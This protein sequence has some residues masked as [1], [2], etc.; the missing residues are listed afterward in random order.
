M[1]NQIYNVSVYS[2]F[3]GLIQALSFSLTN[4]LDENKQIDESKRETSLDE[5]DKTMQT[6]SA[7][8]TKIFEQGISKLGVVPDQNLVETKVLEAKDTEDIYL[9]KENTLLHYE[10]KGS[11]YK[12]VKNKKIRNATDCISK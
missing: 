11:S 4:Y 7:T 6:D 9:L 8:F 10:L 2:Q 3:A 5:E 12:Y 1:K